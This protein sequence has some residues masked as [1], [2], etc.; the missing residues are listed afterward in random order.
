MN[1][2][3][4]VFLGSSRFSTFVLEELETNGFKP[5]LNINNAKEPLLIEKLRKLNADLFIVASFG[6]ILPQE[7]IEMPKFKTL[8]VH[9]SL[10]PHL[11]GPAP[12]QGSILKDNQTGVSIIRM[13]EKMDH[14]PLLAQKPVEIKPWP[15]HYD[16]IEEKL[17]RAGGKLLVETIPGWINGEVKEIPQIDS[18]ATYI[19][20][21]K[22]EDG[23]IN[24]DDNPETNLRKVLAYST[25]PGAYMFFKKKNGDESRIVIKDAEIKDGT[26]Y[27]TRVIPAGKKEM[28]WQDFLRGNS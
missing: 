14:G 1:N 23:L 6:K 17:A 24:M 15:D 20:L 5:I 27:P 22:K 13:D 28:N 3:K 4:I 25:W 19:K 21:I 2:L 26:F 9:P 18:E 12:I 16:V 8:N 7:I 11:R 10:L